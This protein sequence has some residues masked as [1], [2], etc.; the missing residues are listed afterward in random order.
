[1]KILLLAPQ[2]FFQQRGTPIAVRLL[3]ETLT[4]AGHLVDLL[5]YP[6][7]E[8]VSLPGCRL[9]RT[10]RLPGLGGVR[11]GFSWKKLPLDALMAGQATGLLL[12]GEHYD[13]VHAVEEAA[14]IA[15][16]LKR[17]FKVPYIYDMDSSLPEQL[18]D[19][20]SKLAR[21]AGWMARREAAVVRASTGVLAVCPWLAERA[22]AHDP[23]KPVTVLEDISLLGEADASVPANLPKFHG[24]V[25][26]YVGNAE[27]YQGVELLIQ[28]FPGVLVRR[29]DAVLVLVGERPTDIERCQGLARQLGILHAVHC[30]G[31]RP[32]E[33]LPAVLAAASV[34]VS[35][36]ISGHNT[37]MKVYSYLD[38]GRPLVATRLPTHTQV[39]DDEVAVLTEASAQGLAAG[40]LRAMD[41][42]AAA[43]ALASRAKARVAERYTREAFARKL[44]AFYA[45]IAKAIGRDAATPNLPARA[46]ESPC[47]YSV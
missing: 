9:I 32:L 34:L 28:A 16:W 18:V 7:G 26:M 10:L 45:Q 14:F 44:L 41:D 2:P 21:L 47:S 11:P 29:S 5:V 23:G 35:P 39:L 38:S 36:R 19:K 15:R 42:P 31:P 12:R 40:I 13:L 30:V 4:S 1:M 8:D 25:V 37:P 3:A 20:H 46:K 33:A 24:P 17:L 22:R 6:E 27:P 43:A